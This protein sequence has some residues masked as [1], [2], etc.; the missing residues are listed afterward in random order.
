MAIN[1]NILFRAINPNLEN[2]MS[3]PFA[4]IIILDVFTIDKNSYAV[5]VRTFLYFY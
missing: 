2:G 3:S 4:Y 1:T 5:K